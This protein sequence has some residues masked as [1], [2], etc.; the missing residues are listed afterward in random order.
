MQQIDQYERV[1]RDSRVRAA[2]ARCKSLGEIA[3]NLGVTPD[4]AKEWL[5]GLGTREMPPYHKVMTA[6]AVMEAIL[7]PV[8]L[9]R[10]AH[11]AGVS[12]AAL[13]MR[14]KRMGLPTDRAGRAALREQRMA[15]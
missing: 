10:A 14:A 6:Q 9:H 11:E 3:V 7:S 4:V 2:A 8:S 15:S 5:V 12:P 1:I 13:F